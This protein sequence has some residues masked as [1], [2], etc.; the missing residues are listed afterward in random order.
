MDIL[1][2]DSDFLAVNKPPGLATIPG[3][4]DPESVIG[5]LPRQLA[6]RDGGEPRKLLVVHRLD[7]D[8]GGVLLVAKN[9]DAQRALAS[10]FG[11]REVEKTYWLLVAGAVEPADGDINISL[12]TDPK[13]PLAMKP[14]RRRT[15]KKAHTAYRTLEDFGGLT[16]V[17]ARPTT[18]RM[19]QIRVHFASIG[20]PLAVDPIYGSATGICLSSFKP[21]FRMKRGDRERPLIDRLT[22]H[23]LR[24]KFRRPSDNQVMELEAPLPKDFRS[25]LQALRKWAVPF[26]RKPRTPVAVPAVNAADDDQPE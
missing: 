9:T 14:T 25:T 26:R 22:L 19:H 11:R 5:E 16:L 12:E 13:R 24:V 23:A 10:Q 8:T 2:E 18:G 20:H 1:Y 7:Q 17:E 4:T 3:R 6:K 21:D 15:A